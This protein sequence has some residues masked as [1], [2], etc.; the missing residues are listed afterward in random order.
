VGTNATV[1]LE[2]GEIPD[3]VCAAADREHSDLLV[4]GRGLINA[5]RLPTNAYAI[6]R[7][8]TCPVV[9]V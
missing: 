1:L 2:A 9:S 4:I 5:S 8:S 3:A 7:A 6:V